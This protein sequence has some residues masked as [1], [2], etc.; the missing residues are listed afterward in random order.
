M[1]GALVILLL[2]WPA[3]A[4][5]GPHKEGQYGGVTPGEA[6]PRDAASSARPRRPPSKGTLT[7]IGFEARD[8]G[9]QVFFQS[10]AP[11]ELS[12][13]VE[14][15]TLV[16]HLGLRR[17]GRNTWRPIDTRFFDNPLSGIVARAAGATRAHKGRPARAA[18]IVVRIAFKNAKDA[19]EATVRTATEADGRYYAY[20]TFPEG[21]GGPVAPPSSEAPD[22][23]EEAGGDEVEDAPPPPRAPRS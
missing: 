19:R 18:G 14:G 17:L 15:G 22:E 11:F 9:A 5:D 3:H 2:S 12:Q 20:L 1:R 10:V 8:G 7:W 23:P 21:T 13:R 16:V 4:D 6:P